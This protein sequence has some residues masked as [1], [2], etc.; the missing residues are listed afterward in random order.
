MDRDTAIKMIK[1]YP[2]IERVV[3][4]RAHFVGDA[5]VGLLCDYM[6]ELTNDMLTGKFPAGQGI[7]PADDNEPAQAGPARK[8]R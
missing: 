6:E 2:K 1:A 4:L 5:P 8:A 7:A 3:E